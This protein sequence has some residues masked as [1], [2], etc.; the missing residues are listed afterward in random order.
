MHNPCVQPCWG[1]PSGGVPAAPQGAPLPEGE[2]A[3]ASLPG[4][5]RG[6]K[7][8]RPQR[9]QQRLKAASSRFR[10]TEAA[11]AACGCRVLARNTSRCQG[12]GAAPAHGDMWMPDASTPVGSARSPCCAV[13]SWEVSRA[14][15]ELVLAHL[16]SPSGAQGLG[17]STK[18]RA[19][20]QAGKAEEQGGRDVQSDILPFPLDPHLHLL[21]PPWQKCEE[22][23]QHCPPSLQGHRTVPRTRSPVLALCRTRR[24]KGRAGQLLLFDP[25]SEHTGKQSSLGTRARRNPAPSSLFAK[26][27]RVYV[28]TSSWE[29]QGHGA[30][31]VPGKAPLPAAGLDLL[32]PSLSGSPAA[33]WFP[34][35]PSLP[36]VD[37]REGTSHLSRL[38][39]PPAMGKLRPHFAQEFALEGTKAPLQLPPGRGAAAL[40]GLS[41]PPGSGLCKELPGSQST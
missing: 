11:G 40:A 19:E 5:W 39:L 36:Q 8:G 7:R 23:A 15:H 16:S 13:L 35:S 25:R 20:P 29:A 17:M 32:C 31:D 38:A 30:P 33:W 28:Q 2:G 3:A 18:L 27:C 26:P 14:A 21:I 6:R 24:R 4:S 9:C 22:A 37:P 12:Q 41:L 34:N 10:C 1:P